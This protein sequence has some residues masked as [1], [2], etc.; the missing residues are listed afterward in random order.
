RFD[1]PAV[2]VDVDQNRRARDVEVP[3]AVV[4]ELVV[5]LLLAGVEIDGDDALAVESGAGT[6]AAVVVAGRQFDGQIDRVQLF[7]DGNL[8]PHAGVARVHPRFFFPR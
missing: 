4:H 1:R 3:D 7:V 6:M 8:S 5:P 2:D